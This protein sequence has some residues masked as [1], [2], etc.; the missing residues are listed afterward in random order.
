MKKQITPLEIA[1]SFIN[2]NLSWVKNEIKKD[3]PL[4][5]KVNQELKEINPL[6]SERFMSWIMMW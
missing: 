1:E 4:L 6:E 2:G 5:A 3:I